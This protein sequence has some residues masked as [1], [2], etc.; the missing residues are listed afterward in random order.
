MRFGVGERVMAIGLGISLAVSG[1]SEGNNSKEH[2]EGLREQREA[3]FNDLNNAFV[4]A[5][6]GLDEPAIKEVIEIV[7]D[8]FE[9]AEPSNALVN[10]E[11][12]SDTIKLVPYLPEDEELDIEPLAEFQTTGAA[13]YFDNANTV[14]VNTIFPLDVQIS[15]LVHELTHAVQ[16]KR[17]LH[18]T[19]CQIREPD[20]LLAQVQATPHI[21]GQEVLRRIEQLQKQSKVTEQPN[22]DLAIEYGDV[23][24]IEQLV[25]SS[26]GSDRVEGMAQMIFRYTVDYDI[27]KQYNAETADNKFRDY[28]GYDYCSTVGTGLNGS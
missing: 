24:S 5:L 4:E 16:D 18:A 17:G 8:G 14:L 3:A 22:G 27:L 2:N 15:T 12:N 9:Y 19:E 7:G 26:Y 11:S 1:C 23:S 28:M 20:A 10:E 6:S 25:E 21:F 13:V